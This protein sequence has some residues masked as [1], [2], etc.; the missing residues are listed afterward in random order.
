MTRSSAILKKRNRVVVVAYEP[1]PRVSRKL[2]KAPTP[3]WPAFGNVARS[4]DAR[5]MRFQPV[6]NTAVSAPS[7]VRSPVI[8]FMGLSLAQKQITG[9]EDPEAD[10]IARK[11]AW[12]RSTSGS[13]HY[14]TK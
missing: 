9:V 13:R 1:I 10:R 12:L 8:G 14:R 3:I 4:F 6:R 7:A 2:V 5:I 11:T